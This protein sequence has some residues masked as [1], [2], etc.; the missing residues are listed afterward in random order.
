MKISLGVDYGT[1]S[2]RA[3]AVDTATGQELGLSIYNYEH[4]HQGVLLDPRDHHLARQSPADYLTGLER[5]IRGALQQAG[6]SP[7]SVV[8]I[9]VD[10]TGSSPIPV[11]ATNVPL[12][13]NPQWHDRLAAQCWLWKDHTSHEEAAA[14]TRLAACSRPFPTSTPWFTPTRDTP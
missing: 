12:A 7:E 4:G 10:T 2:V 1:N 5:T 8:G 9:G 11:D 6:A 14:I 3:L 13:L